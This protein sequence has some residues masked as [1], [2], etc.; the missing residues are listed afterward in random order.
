M[1]QQRLAPPCPDTG[2]TF[3]RRGGG[4]FLAPAAVTGNGKP[5]RF[6]TNL[7]YQV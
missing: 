2:N 1:I 4:G 5:V 7:L 3:Q 6:V